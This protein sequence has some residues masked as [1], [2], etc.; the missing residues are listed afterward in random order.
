MF[1]D[2]AE[3]VARSIGLGSPVI[4]VTINYRLGV[5]SYFHSREL[6]LDAANQEDVPPAFR[7]TANLGL[8]DSY[9]AVEW[10]G[11]KIHISAYC[12]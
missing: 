1:K 7:S 10:V 6:A 3:I 2:G 9:V 11:G 5:L 12:H 8:L 4:V